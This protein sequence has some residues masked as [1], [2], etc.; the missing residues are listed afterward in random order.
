M[1]LF[2]YTGVQEVTLKLTIKAK[3]REEAE[4]KFKKIWIN[5]HI[6]QDCWWNIEENEIISDNFDDIINED[7]RIED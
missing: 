6:D 2:P 3:N 7:W 5:F 1:T 4:E